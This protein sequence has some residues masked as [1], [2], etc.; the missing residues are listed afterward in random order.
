MRFDDL[1]WRIVDEPGRTFKVHRSIYTDPEIFDLEMKYIYEGNWLYVAHE[2]EI[3]NPGD[4][5]TTTVGRQPRRPLAQF[6]A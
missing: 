2:S 1:N 4:Y 6:Q 5:L 3:A